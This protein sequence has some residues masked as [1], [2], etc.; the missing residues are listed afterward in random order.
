MATEYTTVELF[1]KVNESGEYDCGSTAEEAGE[2][3]E[4]NIGTDNETG[5]RLVKLT[6]KVP[7][8]K[9]LELTGEVT[10]DESESELKVA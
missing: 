5:Y 7:L 3:F 6:V 2:R 4:E 9:P 8:P 10:V 1:V